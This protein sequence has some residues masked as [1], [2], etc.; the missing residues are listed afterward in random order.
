MVE[1][2]GWLVALRVCVWGHWLRGCGWCLGFEGCGG[3]RGLEL[4]IRLR[5]RVCVGDKLQ[6][7]Y[8]RFFMLHR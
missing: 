8:I 3:S 7:N 2:G 6:A 1:L 4:S 5:R